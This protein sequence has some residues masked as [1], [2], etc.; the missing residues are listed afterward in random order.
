[1]YL[2]GGRLQKFQP[3]SAFPELQD[4]HLLQLIEG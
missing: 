2:A 4:G 1:M 3:A